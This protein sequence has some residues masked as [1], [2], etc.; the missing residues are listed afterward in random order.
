VTSR[1]VNLA[2]CL[3]ELPTAAR[4][5]KRDELLAVVRQ[6]VLSDDERAACGRAL[7]DWLADTD[8]DEATRRRVSAAVLDLGYPWALH[9]EPQFLPK[10][11]D[12]GRRHRV[13]AGLAVLATVAF[14]TAVLARL[15]LESLL[16]APQ[17]PTL[18]ERPQPIPSPLATRTSPPRPAVPERWDEL[19]H[20]SQTCMQDDPSALP[21]VLDAARAHA[22]LSRLPRPT[23]D[24][25]GAIAKARAAEHERL[26][27]ELYRR[28]LSIA[29]TGDV[30]A[31]AIVRA[32]RNDGDWVDWTTGPAAA[33]ELDG[34]ELR[35]PPSDL[36]CLTVH[37]RAW[38]AR[39][40]R[41]RQLDDVRAAEAA[42]ARRSAATRTP[43]L[44]LSGLKGLQ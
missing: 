19:L 25:A 10:A 11:A 40:A 9:L 2:T 38:A 30:T 35:C 21:C 8:V 31:P 28:Y 43:E 26:A 6:G 39:A 5:L 27:R 29:P 36:N 41:T 22:F 16:Q 20:T 18:L 15:A 24:L 17:R 7:V 4:N 13:A 14:S 44:R 32:L 12:C 1:L 37:A 23:T 42:E 34:I 3:S 33:K